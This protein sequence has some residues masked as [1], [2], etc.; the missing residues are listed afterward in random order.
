M[1]ADSLDLGALHL[2]SGEGRRL[3]LTVGMDPYLLA[4]ERY[5][6]PGGVL[7]VTLDISRT[8]GLGYALRLRFQAAVAG[9]CMRCLEPAA[10]QLNIDVREVFQPGGG[11]ELESPYVRREVLDLRAWA[12]DSLALS[13]PARL[14]CRP[15]CLGLCAVCG[16]NLN[17]AGAGHAHPRSPDPR[18]A[19]LSQLHLR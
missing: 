7:A 12:R 10:P 2:R 15:D 18:W 5:G 16:A 1:R 19:K 6:V 17:Q 11:E 4:G 13:L 9:P 14:L 8:T 3:A